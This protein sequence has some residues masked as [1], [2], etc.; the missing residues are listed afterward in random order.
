[1][2]LALWKIAPPCVFQ[3]SISPIA[4]HEIVTPEQVTETLQKMASVVDRQNAGDPL[5]RP[6]APGFDGLAFS[7][8]VGLIFKG[9]AQP[10]GYTEDTSRAPARGE[11]RRPLEHVPEKS[12]NYFGTC[13]SSFSGQFGYTQHDEGSWRILAV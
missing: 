13:S 1:M 6:M 11:G 3:A 4:Y 5:Y 2:T 10:N 12:S 9:R 7:S 8:G